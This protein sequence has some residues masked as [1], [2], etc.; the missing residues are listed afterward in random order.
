MLKKHAMRVLLFKTSKDKESIQ[1]TLALFLTEVADT[2]L[3]VLSGYSQVPDPD[4]RNIGR[5]PQC[6]IE[7]ALL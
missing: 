5:I 7:S 1:S 2:N 6:R 4:T 3:I